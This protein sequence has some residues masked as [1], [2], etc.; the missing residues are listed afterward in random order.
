MTKQRLTPTQIATLIHANAARENPHARQ[1][2]TEQ[3]TL[4]QAAQSTLDALERKGLVES[5]V[6]HRADKIRYRLTPAG[7]VEVRGP[8]TEEPRP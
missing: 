8:A 7:V 2:W 6:D 4:R 1:G 3:Y 5:Y